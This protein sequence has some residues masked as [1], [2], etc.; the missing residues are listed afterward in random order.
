[1]CPQLL[2]S[3]KVSPQF[4]LCMNKINAKDLNSNQSDAYNYCEQAKWHPPRYQTTQCL[5]LY[6]VAPVFGD[7]KNR[8]LDLQV[9]GWV[10]G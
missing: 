8:D 1:M 10:S 6:L 7:H 3:N 4:Q 9:E 5:G 2:Q